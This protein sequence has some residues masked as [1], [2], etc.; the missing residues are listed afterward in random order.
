MLENIDD[1]NLDLIPVSINYN[2]NGFMN[3][4]SYYQ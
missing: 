2:L 4:D 3:A 1:P